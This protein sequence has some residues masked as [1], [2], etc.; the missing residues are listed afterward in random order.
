MCAL[1]ANLPLKEV[2]GRF[3]YRREAIFLLSLWRGAAA[4]ASSCRDSLH[5]PSHV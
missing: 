5:M 3:E 1:V 2:K 4:P